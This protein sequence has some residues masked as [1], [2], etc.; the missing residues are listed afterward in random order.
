MTRFRSLHLLTIFS[1]GLLSSAPA[2]AESMSCGNR[3]VSTGDSLHQVRSVCGAPDVASH[4]IEYQA[5]PAHSTCSQRGDKLIC[6]NDIP[7]FFAV[8]IDDWVYDFGR[9][10]FTRRLTFEKGR[11]TGI[12]TGSYGQE[13]PQ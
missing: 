7:Q 4:R 1:A 12:D 13:P 9:N 6:Q 8:E 2:G 5:V 3:L 10:R 11:L